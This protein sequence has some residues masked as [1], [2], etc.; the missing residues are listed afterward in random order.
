MVGEPRIRVRPVPT[1]LE[2]QQNL[3]TIGDKAYI[4]PDMDSQVW[5]D[6]KHLILALREVNV[7]RANRTLLSIRVSSR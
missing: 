4:S 2:G 5:N 6:G 7:D 1:L 3:A